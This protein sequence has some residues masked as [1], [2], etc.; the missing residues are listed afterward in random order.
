MKQA[1]ICFLICSFC[2]SCASLHFNQDPEPLKPKQ[3]AIG[4][5]NQG[6][7]YFNG[8][9]LGIQ[10]SPSISMKIGLGNNWE[11]RPFG[12]FLWN[13]NLAPNS[14]SASLPTTSFLGLGIDLKKAFVVSTNAKNEKNYVTGDLELSI[15]AETPPGKAFVGVTLYS[16][17]L[18][19]SLIFGNSR[20]HYGV[21]LAWVSI[22]G[23]E[24]DVFIGFRLGD[25]IRLYGSLKAGVAISGAPYPGYFALFFQPFIQAGL[26]TEV[27]FGK[28]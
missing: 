27:V 16:L 26:G 14:P 23:V 21:S 24:P 4:I 7:L 22:A 25:R 11:I 3:A 12:A 17:A 13:I 5:G 19:P 9:G 20:F 1:S 10:Y 18:R 28:L 8:A 6:F 2:I 15:Y